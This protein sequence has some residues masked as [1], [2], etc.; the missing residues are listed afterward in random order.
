MKIRCGRCTESGRLWRSEEPE[1][2]NPSSKSG[3]GTSWSAPRWGS[4]TR[5]FVRRNVTRS[6]RMEVH[7]WLCAEKRELSRPN[8]GA[9]VAV[10]GET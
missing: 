3:R 7:A 5:G 2:R 1:C 9:C 6:V 4:S 8:R 10:C